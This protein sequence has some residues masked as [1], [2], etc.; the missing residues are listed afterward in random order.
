MLLSLDAQIILGEVGMTKLHEMSIPHLLS[1][2]SRLERM[3]KIMAIITIASTAFYI[4]NYL[5][6]SNNPELDPQR[7]EAKENINGKS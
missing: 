2:L 5:M 6:M 4:L 7:I 3:V 1:L